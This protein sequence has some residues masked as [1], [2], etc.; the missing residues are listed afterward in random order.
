MIHSK[1]TNPADLPHGMLIIHIWAKPKEDNKG[2]WSTTL[3]F[4]W[5]IIV[6]EEK[7]PHLVDKYFSPMKWND[8]DGEEKRF[9]I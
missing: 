6:R 8:Y 2:A 1:H 9:M 3:S 7:M 5:F 4:M